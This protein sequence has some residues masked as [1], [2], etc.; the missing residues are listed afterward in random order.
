ASLAA[1]AAALVAGVL[2]LVMV[3]APGK[4]ASAEPTGRVSGALASAPGRVAG[5][6]G[7]RPHVEEATR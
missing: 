7:A 5:T 3:R 4:R 6:P 2:V 1:G